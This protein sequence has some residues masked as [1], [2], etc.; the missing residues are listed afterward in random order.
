LLELLINSIKV[1][2]E[3]VM[4]RIFS[5]VIVSASFVVG[6]VVLPSFAFAEQENREWYNTTSTLNP[7]KGELQ[8]QSDILEGRFLIAILGAVKEGH[9]YVIDVKNLHSKVQMIDDC[10]KAYVKHTHDFLKLEEKHIKSFDKCLE[11]Y[12]YP[13][14]EKDDV[15]LQD[16]ELKRQWTNY[17]VD[18]RYKA[19]KWVGWNKKS[20]NTYDVPHPLIVI[21]KIATEIGQ[22]SIA[23]CEDKKYRNKFERLVMDG[24]KLILNRGSKGAASYNQKLEEIL[25]ELEILYHDHSR[26]V[27]NQEKWVDEE[28]RAT[29][30]GIKREDVVE[31][32]K[33]IRHFML[34][35]DRLIVLEKEEQVKLGLIM[36]NELHERYSCML[37]LQ[38][39]R[40]IY[41]NSGCSMPPKIR[42]MKL[43]GDRMASRC[44]EFIKNG[45]LKNNN[46]DDIGDIDMQNAGIAELIGFYKMLVYQGKQRENY[47]ESLKDKGGNPLMEYIVEPL[48]K[49]AE[50]IEE[51]L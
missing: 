13:R 5:V 40:T 10:G 33:R 16:K 14:L 35:A 47:I 27:E 38:D 51:Q 20:V 15:E 41:L 26:F 39:A 30:N 7:E 12:N 25:K 22:F 1:Y 50:P 8:R 9:P 46:E 32:A 24:T 28:G 11:N 18:D 34:V 23:A 4:K 3:V 31:L 2:K 44:D 19:S 49:R 43:L 37:S 21:A 6:I 17:T 48:I 45:N 29:Y 36:A 42:G